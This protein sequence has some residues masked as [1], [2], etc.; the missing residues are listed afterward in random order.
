MVEI[1]PDVTSVQHEKAKSEFIALLHDLIRNTSS[2]YN[3]VLF[4]SFVVG[5]RGMCK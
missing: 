4:V 5:G 1:S 3:K 2:L